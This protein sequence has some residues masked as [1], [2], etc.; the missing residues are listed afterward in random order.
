MNKIATRIIYIYIYNIGEKCDKKF[1]VTDGLD[2][3]IC[4]LRKLHM[5]Y[6]MKNMI[7]KYYAGF[8]RKKN[9]ETNLRT[10]HI[11]V[12]GINTFWICKSIKLL[13]VKG[14]GAGRKETVDAQITDLL[15][16]VWWK[17]WYRGTIVTLTT[18]AHER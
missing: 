18:S 11:V 5:M 9:I 6:I 8:Y 17:C 10:G 1:K 12:T 14:V 15:M 7:I 3:K 16:C 4:T 2:L 13:P